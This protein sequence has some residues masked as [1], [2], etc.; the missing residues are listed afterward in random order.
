MSEK[1]LGRGVE[2]LVAGGGKV[3]ERLGEEGVLN[4]AMGKSEACL[5]VMIM[6]TVM[7][8][9]SR[10]S[11]KGK[12]LLIPSS[13]RYSFSHAP[14]PPPTHLPLSLLHP[15]DTL[16]TSFQTPCET[17]YRIQKGGESGGEGKEWV[18]GGD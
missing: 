12:C 3:K 2:S 13:F 18:G 7:W 16:Q 1:G 10:T 15:H 5:L 11:V 17:G 9:R 8:G 6:M 14:F 4:Q